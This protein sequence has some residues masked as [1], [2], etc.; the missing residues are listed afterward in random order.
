VSHVKFSLSQFHQNGENENGKAF[1]DTHGL[2]C[3]CQNAG[4][5]PSHFRYVL[6]DKTPHLQLDIFTKG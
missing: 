2:L 5:V 3:I 6:A 1:G 4:K